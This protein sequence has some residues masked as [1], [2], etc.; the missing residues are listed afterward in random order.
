MAEIALESPCNPC[1]KRPGIPAAYNHPY[2][3][4]GYQ[5]YPAPPKPPRIPSDLRK[6]I[7]EEKRASMTEE[8]LKELELMKKKK[9]KQPKK[10]NVQAILNNLACPEPK[11]KVVR[12][13]L[14]ELIA[15]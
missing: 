10:I 4:R 15:L 13:H 5:P 12:M 11:E 6:S 2:H 7:E 3:S 14:V 9:K 8:E 1:S